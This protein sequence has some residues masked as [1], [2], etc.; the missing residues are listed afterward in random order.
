MA[1]SAASR[2]LP[3]CSAPWRPEALSGTRSGHRHGHDRPWIAV[4]ASQGRYG[5]LVLISPIDRSLTVAPH[6]R[7]SRTAR[8]DQRRILTVT[9]LPAT[10]APV[11]AAGWIRSSSRWPTAIAPMPAS[12]RSRITQSSTRSRSSEAAD[13]RVRGEIG[14]D[15]DYLQSPV[16]RGETSAGAP[17]ARSSQWQR[18]RVERLRDVRDPMDQLRPPT[19]TSCSVS[20]TPTPGGSWKSGS[21]GRRY[22]VMVFVKICGAAPPAGHLRRVQ[23][24]RGLEVPRRHRVAGR[25]GHHHRMRRDA[26]LPR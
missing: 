18:R 25:A 7:P 17:S 6:R 24:H 19:A 20:G 4:E 1:S 5:R 8:R 14:H 16:R 3:S 2:W 11:A 23:R 26:V 21:D 12:V 22:G 15:F 9:L 10:P 13:R